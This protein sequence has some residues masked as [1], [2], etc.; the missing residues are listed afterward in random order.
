MPVAE[1]GLKQYVIG[2]LPTIFQLAI[3][4][5]MVRRKLLTDL[6]WFFLYT[7]Y[8]M[9][10]YL[11]I[12]AEFAT[13]V[14]D[15]TYFYTFYVLQCFS[16]IFALCVIYEVF[17]SVLTP[18]EALRH[19]GARLY[20]FALLVLGLI[21]GVMVIF[22][23][24]AETYRFVQLINLSQLGLRFIQVGLL[25]LLFATARAL[26]LSWRSYSF[27]IALGYGTFAI[28]DLLLSAIRVK[29]GLPVLR[30]VSLLG[31]LA[32]IVAALIWSWYILQPQRVAQ[33]VRVIP[34]NDIAK[35]NEKLEEL[36][37][38]KAA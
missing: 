16:I 7:L 3:L 34:Y 18:Y 30:L 38:R 8:Q 25:M 37:K 10:V 2:L 21:A 29:Y 5:V 31:P 14:S 6:R 17:G 20:L 11:I 35:W 22:G 32:Y 24:G 36:L 33:P 27:G 26:A 23:S 4:I 19:L 28:V 9:L 12:T 15:L 1:V 13:K